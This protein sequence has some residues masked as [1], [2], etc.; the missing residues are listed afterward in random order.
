MDVK[1]YCGVMV[2]CDK[3]SVGYKIYNLATCRIVNTVHLR[4]N[5]ST[6][7]FSNSPAKLFL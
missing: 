2:G 3:D 5:E 7:G 4:F 1:S 6:P